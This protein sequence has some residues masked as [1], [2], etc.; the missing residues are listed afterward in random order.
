MIAFFTMLIIMA[1][2]GSV[3]WILMFSHLNED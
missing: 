3:A 2:L 1:S